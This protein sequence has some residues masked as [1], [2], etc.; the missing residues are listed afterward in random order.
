MNFNK[1]PPNLAYLGEFKIKLIIVGHNKNE[2]F[3]INFNYIY[4]IIFCIIEYKKK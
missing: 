3:Q 4:R 2:S 1:K